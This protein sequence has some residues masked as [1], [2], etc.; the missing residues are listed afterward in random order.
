MINQA[1]LRGYVFLLDM[2]RITIDDVPD[3]YNTAINNQ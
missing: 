2:K 3:P 1:K